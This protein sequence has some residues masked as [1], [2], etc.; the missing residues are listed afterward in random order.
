MYSTIGIVN[1]VTELIGHTPLVRINKIVDV[2]KSAELVG[3]LESFNPGGSL[4]DRA[5][6]FMIEEAERKG[7]LKKGSTI[8]EPTSGNTGIGLAMI[9]AVKGY[10]CILTMPES[11][12]L[13][14][15]YLLK[16][17]GAEVI[18]TPTKLPSAASLANAKP[19]SLKKSEKKTPQ[20]FLEGPCGR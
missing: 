10:R 13:E 4:K 9:C 14:R 12:S 1:N 11:M 3:K 2:N 20:Y 7:Y 19:K 6:L 8:I 16:L 15:I 18:L 17:Y 5:C